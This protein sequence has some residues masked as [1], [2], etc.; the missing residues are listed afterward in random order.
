MAYT[1]PD[2]SGETL[3]KLQEL[4]RY[5]YSPGL[6]AAVTVENNGW[7]EFFEMFGRSK[8]MAE[9]TEFKNVGYL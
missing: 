2:P 6:A 1:D 5:L 9:Q 3:A 8:Y 7:V 4:S